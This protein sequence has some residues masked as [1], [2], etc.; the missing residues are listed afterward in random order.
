LY[1]IVDSRERNPQ[2]LSRLFYG[3]QIVNWSFAHSLGESAVINYKLPPRQAVVEVGTDV[4]NTAQKDVPN[5]QLSRSVRPPKCGA[6]PT[7]VGSVLSDDVCDLRVRTLVA[8]V[9]KCLA[10]IFRASGQRSK[11]VDGSCSRKARRDGSSNQSN[12]CRCANINGRLTYTA[13]DTALAVGL[14]QSGLAMQ[15]RHLF[16]SHS[17]CC[18]PLATK[19]RTCPD[20]LL[21]YSIN[22][23]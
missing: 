11:H 12:W 6:W 3:K 18:I 23:C 19:R 7:A 9:P 2:V 1:E 8:P 17:C 20:R 22:V 4:P 5:N 13:S 21:H 15:S 10:L 16:R 14:C